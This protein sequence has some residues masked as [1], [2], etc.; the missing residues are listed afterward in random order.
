MEFNTLELNV[1][2][3]ESQWR[4]AS[5]RVISDACAVHD[6]MFRRKSLKQ[7]TDSV[8][9]QFSHPPTLF[10]PLGYHTTRQQNGDFLITTAFKVFV[11]YYSHNNHYKC[12]T[13]AKKWNS[14]FQNSQKYIQVI[15]Q[16]LS[17]RMLCK[18]SDNSLSGCED[19]RSQIGKYVLSC[20]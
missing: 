5:L 9:Q 19:C 4:H 7:A 10:P 17:D 8:E 16:L 13:A 11:Y 14:A 18:M 2:N 3:N 15:H 6:L 12:Q 20:M 1:V